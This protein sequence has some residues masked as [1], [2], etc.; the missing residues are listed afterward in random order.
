VGLA[1]ST[2]TDICCPAIPNRRNQNEQ[3]RTHSTRPRLGSR[4]FIY[5]VHDKS[6]DEDAIPL[7]S[8]LIHG[9]PGL[10]LAAHKHYCLNS[11]RLHSRIPSLIKPLTQSWTSPTGKNV[12]YNSLPGFLFSSAPPQNW[13]DVETGHLFDTLVTAV[14]GYS[15][16]A[17]S[18]GPTPALEQARP[19]SP[20]PP[21]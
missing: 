1:K 4:L 21:C 2:A 12:S 17:L 15:K 18:S 16:Y 13:S 8:M 5:F 10:C 19:R 9:W 14:L 11:F 6:D 3:A 7:L 20:T